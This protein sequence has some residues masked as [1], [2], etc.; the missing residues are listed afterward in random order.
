M[1][2]DSSAS[3]PS[4]AR[5]SPLNMPHPVKSP[6]SHSSLEAVQRPPYAHSS[7]LMGNH[8]AS[9]IPNMIDAFMTSGSSSTVHI[10]PMKLN[11]SSVPGQSSNI[12]CPT[13]LVQ[14]PS[15]KINSKSSQLPQPASTTFSLSPKAETAIRD[16]LTGGSITQG[17]PV[18][19]QPGQQAP[20][21]HQQQVA[22]LAALNVSVSAAS[23]FPSHPTSVLPPPPSHHSATV[24]FHPASHV[25]PIHYNELYRH[26]NP[27]LAKGSIT[28]GTPLIMPGGNPSGLPFIPTSQHYPSQLLSVNPSSRKNDSA[29]DF[30]AAVHGGNKRS[31]KSNS[32][33]TAQIPNYDFIDRMKNLESVSQLPLYHRPF[34]PNY[35][36]SSKP[37]APSSS[38]GNNV[39]TKSDSGNINQILIDFN[40]SKQM[41]PRRSSASSDKESERTTSHQDSGRL[42]PPPPPSAPPPG[43]HSDKHH[44]RTFQ[45]SPAPSP[46]AI[47][48][49]DN[50][51]TGDKNAPMLDQQ[52]FLHWNQLAF[53]NRQ[54]VI[55]Q[56]YQHQNP[57]SKG[58]SVIQSVPPR[59]DLIKNSLSPRITNAAAGNVHNFPP[60]HDALAT[61]VNA[62]IQQPSLSV[63]S[64]TSSTT[65]ASV[66]S[67]SSR[68]NK[69]GFEKCFSE[70]FAQHLGT[71]PQTKQAVSN[72]IVYPPILNDSSHP[73]DI[74]T[75]LSINNKSKE[76]S[77]SNRNRVGSS[78]SRPSSTTSSIVY[79]ENLDLMAKVTGG[80]GFPPGTGP[81]PFGMLP[82]TG[83][84]SEHERH[85]LLAE[86]QK[87]KLNFYP[88]DF[89]SAL[90][91]HQRV[92]TAAASGFR[93]ELLNYSPM[94]N[95]NPAGDRNPGLKFGRELNPFSPEHFERGLRQQ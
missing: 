54:N 34:S 67:I 28:Q 3:G 77:K 68:L 24:S 85:L 71:N 62:A 11:R 60:E 25:H 94:L 88:A 4:S 43:I 59:E 72:R 38:S 84:L 46:S 65:S 64:S 22:A 17:T 83:H 76:D 47:Y 37:I 31:S 52:A 20:S 41:Q 1:K 48:L 53:L 61:L 92:N 49:Q 51:V 93:P 78:D 35:P 63:P 42:I 18:V 95:V 57:S 30:A 8:P 56:C 66:S 6:F 50:R 55:Q 80:R 32:S 36:L 26:M 81:T 87:K 74:I 9:R 14:A 58:T 90:E 7:N 10:D 70:S 29:S 86:H 82:N 89:H 23:K 73:Q 2:I 12:Y 45:I 5:S 27:E 40:T 33:S 21:P 69:E 44:P 75:D 16:K 13:G 39:N 91:H 15:L 79:A 19:L